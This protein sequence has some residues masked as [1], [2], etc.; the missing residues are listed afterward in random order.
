MGGPH[1]GGAQYLG[2]NQARKN[3]KSD[4]VSFYGDKLIVYDVRIN[5]G[6]TGRY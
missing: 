2:A 1:P 3:G 6:A 5:V 4:K